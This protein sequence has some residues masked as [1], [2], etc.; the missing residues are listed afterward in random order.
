M[1][2]LAFWFPE[3]R[4]SFIYIDGCISEKH[5]FE[6]IN[7]DIANTELSGSENLVQKFLY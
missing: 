6:L 1:L 4:L 7:L 3:I 5:N 2:L